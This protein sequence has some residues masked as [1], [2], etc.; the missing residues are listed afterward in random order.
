M[1][2]TA[3]SPARAGQA[4]GGHLRR[5]ITLAHA[6]AAQTSGE[7]NASGTDG[8]KPGAGCGPDP[9]ALAALPDLELAVL[10][11]QLETLS[12]HLD[13][14]KVRCAGELAVRTLAGRYRDTGAATPVAMLRD[15]L[16][17]SG[18]EAARRL[19][20]AAAFVPAVD[21]ISQTVAPPKQPVL[22]A[23]FLAGNCSLEN[24]LVASRAVAE[25][26]R[27]AAGGRIGAAEV[28]A[29]EASLATTAATESPDFLA[30]GARRI[31]AHLDP[32][33]QEPTEAEL[34]AKEGIHFGAPRRGMVRFDGHLTQLSYEE[35]MAVM[36]TGTNPRGTAGILAGGAFDAV[37]VPGQGAPPAWATGTGAASAAS[38][39]G[40]DGAGGPPQ[41]ASGAS[42]G[43]A[44]AGTG[45]GGG[46]GSGRSHR[47]GRVRQPATQHPGHPSRRRRLRGPCLGRGYQPGRV[48]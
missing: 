42:D 23:A 38:A 2:I 37:A 8:A 48:R 4:P 27:L 13:A 44:G 41:G 12:R 5:I 43:M 14:L 16:A 46:D 21:P 31:L 24:A 6:A 10:A 28:D 19:A 47:R 3:F 17:I 33:G 45:P 32:D 25:A 35:L 1:G 18:A 40:D 34:L 9:L 26:S 30:R 11:G 29:V 7:A 39:A 22:G 36:G 15:A 20:L